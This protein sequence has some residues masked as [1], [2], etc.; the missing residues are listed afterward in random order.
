MEPLWPGVV[1][2]MVII[3]LLVLSSIIA[4]VLVNVLLRDG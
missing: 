2:F 1:W 3:V 4:T